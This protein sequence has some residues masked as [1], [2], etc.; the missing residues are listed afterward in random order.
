MSMRPALALLLLWSLA[1]RPA[2]EG[3]QRASPPAAVSVRDGRMSIRATDAAVGSVVADVARKAGPEV[4]GTVPADRTVSAAFD[5][6]TLDEG[7]RRL[8]GDLSFA[9][10]YGQDGRLRTI[11]LRGGPQGGGPSPG[12][13]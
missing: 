10:V 6:A 2:A 7:L 12:G 1:G 13:E 9:L 5:D 4:K 3:P 11:G 8:L